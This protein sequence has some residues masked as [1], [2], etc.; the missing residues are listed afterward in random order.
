MKSIRDVSSYSVF[1]VVMTRLNAPKCED[2]AKFVPHGILLFG[3]MTVILGGLTAKS[4]I[5]ELRLAIQDHA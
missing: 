5:H 1:L 2:A 4:M 3:A